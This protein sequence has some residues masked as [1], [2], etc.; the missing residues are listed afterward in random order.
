MARPRIETKRPQLEPGPKQD[1]KR[2]DARD[3]G[4]ASITRIGAAAASA[5]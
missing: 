4:T 1:G 3:L 5:A 2:A